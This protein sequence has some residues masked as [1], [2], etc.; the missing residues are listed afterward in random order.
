MLVL[1]K[2]DIK[3]CFSMSDAIEASKVSVKAY[4]AGQAKVPLRVNLPVNQF[5]GQSLYMPAAV[6]GDI[7]AVGVKVVSVYP[8][9]IDRG[10]PSVPAS[11]V[12]V[13]AETG[14]VS[15]IMDGTFL[16][17]LR[18][19]AVQG[20]ATDLLAR[21]DAKIAAIIGTGGQA[22]QQSLAMLTVRSIE[23]L[24][25]YDINLER[26]QA[27]A[28]ELDDEFG[29][30]FNTKFIAVSSPKEAVS[31]ADIITSVTTSKRPTFD[32]QDIKPGTHVNGVGAYTSEMIELPAE[33]F[34]KA[35]TIVFDTVDGV[36]NEAG[37]V[38]NALNTKA[39]QETD[40]TGEL[41][42]LVLGSITG[43]QSKQGITLFKTVGSAVLDVVTAQ[44][45]VKKALEKGIGT[46]IDL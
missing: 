23:E 41:G 11:M 45:I 39:I 13:D 15:A 43:R 9:N 33:I 26:A 30:L 29:K 35:E 5:N 7:N 3:A 42:Q 19:G 44:L 34:A 28:K 8:D 25:V 1:T 24:R 36:V 17:Q 22:I 20:A 46:I 10:L 32:A 14:V 2:E 16:T 4:S 18:T 37:D 12:V 27:F 31:G 6:E 21:K 40:I 38:M